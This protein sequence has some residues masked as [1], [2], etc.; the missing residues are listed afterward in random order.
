MPYT[1]Q[2]GKMYRMPTHFGPRTGP[3]RGPDDRT[4]ANVDTP[5]TTTVSVS[6]LTDADALKSA[7]PIVGFRPS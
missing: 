2:P 5:K 6:F 1:F 3:R 4:F 7:L